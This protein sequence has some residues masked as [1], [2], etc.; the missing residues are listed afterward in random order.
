MVPCKDCIVLAIC[1]AKTNQDIKTF[2]FSEMTSEVV[3]LMFDAMIYKLR[4]NCS[5]LKDYFSAEFML[6]EHSGFNNNTD[7][8]KIRYN[9]IRNCFNLTLKDQ[10]RIDK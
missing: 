9:E 5:I 8:S 3:P 1:K 4:G 7:E 6:R 2:T 10:L